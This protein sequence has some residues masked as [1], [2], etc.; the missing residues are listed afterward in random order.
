V[1]PC[2]GDN[3]EAEL[4]DIA[5]QFESRTAAELFAATMAKEPLRVAAA[6]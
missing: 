2:L 5:M 4:F 3:G 1:H 6:R